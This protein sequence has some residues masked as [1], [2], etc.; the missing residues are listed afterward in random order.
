MPRLLERA[1]S[2][3]ART[4]LILTSFPFLITF[5]LPSGLQARDLGDTPTVVLDSTPRLPFSTT[6]PEIAQIQQ[7]ILAADSRSKI[8]D[9]FFRRYSSP[10]AGLG[11]DIVG[12]ADKYHL[13]YGLLPA[14]SFCESQGG[15]TAPA[16]SYNAWGW[17]I[18]GENSH[19]FGSWEEA[20]EKVSKGIKVNYADKGLTTPEEMMKKYAPASNGSWA[21]CVSEFLAELE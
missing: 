15:K 18:Y 19:S 4:G 11:V 2:F 3:F 9:D 14:I 5:A 20:I 7:T 16:E 12:T 21:K 13:P 10:M 8:I 17:Y 1:L 6:A